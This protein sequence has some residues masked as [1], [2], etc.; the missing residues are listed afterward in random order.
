MPTTL[1][2]GIP[3]LS[4]E[5][6]PFRNLLCDGGVDTSALSNISVVSAPANLGLFAIALDGLVRLRRKA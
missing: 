3:P 1:D 6:E 2:Y 5:N 4:T